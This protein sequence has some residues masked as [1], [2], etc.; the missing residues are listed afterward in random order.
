[1]TDSVSI[2][3][4]AFKIQEN[5]NGVDQVLPD[6]IILLDLKNIGSLLIDLSRRKVSLTDDQSSADAV[7][8]LS[9]PTLLALKSGS[10]TPA[11]GVMTQ[12][13]KVHGD[14]ELL[15][16]LKRLMSP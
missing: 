2:N 16:C 5:I 11:T 6:G 4:I 1:M 14:L 15:A 9:L 3:D 8:R 10:L 7:V 13:I 12:K